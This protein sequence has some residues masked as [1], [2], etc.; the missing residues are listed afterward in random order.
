M[1]SRVVCR[2]IEKMFELLKEV[3]TSTE[4]SDKMTLKTLISQKAAAVQDALATNGTSF[5]SVLAASGFSRAKV[6]PFIT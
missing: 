3:M 6:I 2:N 5:A 4:F 1:H